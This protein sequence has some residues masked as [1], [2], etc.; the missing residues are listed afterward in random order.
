LIIAN[1]TVRIVQ[2]ISST[3]FSQTAR[4]QTCYGK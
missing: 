4:N 1:K 3:L 2:L